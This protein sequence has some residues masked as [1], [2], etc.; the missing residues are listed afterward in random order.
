[1]EDDPDA[2]SLLLSALQGRFSDLAFPELD[3][4][5]DVAP[6]ITKYECAA[7]MKEFVT[8]WLAKTVEYAERLDRCGFMR[9]M[10]KLVGYTGDLD[11]PE[12]FSIVTRKLILHPD[13]DFRQ[14]VFVMDTVKANAVCMFIVGKVRVFFASHTDITNGNDKKEAPTPSETR[15]RSQLHNKQVHGRPHLE[16]NEFQGSHIRQQQLCFSILGTP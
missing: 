6:L 3:M 2:I 13:V 14:F 15:L 7:N 5:E 12:Y 10:K 8:A 16:V 9:F 11:S 4:L 1:M